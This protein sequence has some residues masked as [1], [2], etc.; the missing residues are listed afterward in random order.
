[1]AGEVVKTRQRL[2][3]ATWDLICREYVESDHLT[4]DQLATRH[5]VSK[6][7]LRKRAQPAAEDWPAQRAKRFEVE[8][9][10]QQESLEDARRRL[11]TGDVQSRLHYVALARQIV[12]RIMEAMR[13]GA[14]LSPDAISKYV[15][16]LARCQQIEFVAMGIDPVRD[17]EA[18]RP[19]VNVI[20]TEGPP[21][22]GDRPMMPRS[23]PAPGH[24]DDR[25][26]ESRRPTVGEKLP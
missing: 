3:Q 15:S 14:R 20:I 22:R 10:Q 24:N 19:P 2:S 6:E 4:Y 12:R 21:E 23:G 11:L 5:G 13:P 25:D 8:E 7:T 1:M 16:A 9:R 18:A 26:I 17:R